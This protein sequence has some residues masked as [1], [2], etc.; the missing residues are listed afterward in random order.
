MKQRLLDFLRR[1]STIAF[2]ALTAL[3]AICMGGIFW[4][5]WALDKAPIEP[6]NAIFYPIDE[7]ARWFR[8]LVAGHDFVPSD[9]MHV[10]GSMYFW[11]ELQYALAG[12]LAALGVV[13]YL[14]GRRVSLLGAYGGGAAYGLMGYTF[15]LFSAGHLGWFVWMMYGPFAFGLVDRCVRKGK[16]RNWALL[17]AVLAW[18][19]ARQSDMWLLFAVLTFLY[20]LW[21]LVREWKR[22]K[23]LRVLAGVCVTVVCLCAVGLPQFMRALTSDLAGREAQI[24]ATSGK[25]TDETVDKSADERWRFCTSWSLPPEDTAEFVCAEIHGGSSDPRVSPKNPYKGRLGQQIVVPQNAAGQRHPVTGET[26]KAGE[27]FWM[28]YRQHSLYFGF[29]TVIFSILGLVGWW[30]YALR[31]PRTA[32]QKPRTFDSAA[33]TA[34]R[35]QQATFS[36][37]PFWIAT[38]VLFY[39]CALG[40]F[41]PFYKLVY[42]LPFGSTLRA[43]VKFV[44]LLEFCVAALAGFGFEAAWRGF[45][46]DGKTANIAVKCIL[47]AAAVGNVANLACIDAKYCAVED[48]AIQKAPNDAADDVVKLDGGKVFTVTDPNLQMQIWSPI[49]QNIQRILTQLNMPIESNHSR[50]IQGFIQDVEP[51]IPVVLSD[52]RLGPSDKNSIIALLKPMLTLSKDP[53]CPLLSLGNREQLTKKIM[54]MKAVQESFGVHL[55]ET[56]TS[57]DDA[58]FFFL[59]KWLYEANAVLRWI[60]GQQ[61]PVGYYSLQKDGIRKAAPESCTFVLLQVEG[62]P[63]P[64]PKEEPVPDRKSQVLTLVSVLATFGLLGWGAWGA[65]RRKRT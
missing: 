53:N 31:K 63:A 48:V 56:A 38:A 60:P 62:V 22:I 7:A 59:P 39:F 51:K 29:L 34:N 55:V 15:T 1:P 43:P 54:K 52:G 40:C 24:A 36:D 57:F 33:P 16:W 32:S 14:R 47:V 50:S 42:A 21:T 45:R 25:S 49:Q 8:E 9:L 3:Y 2:L 44:H 26:L 13:F 23:F 18:A 12:Y 41:T 30:F 4:G 37:V 20:G 64:P 17:G 6:D 61:K 11:Q 35:E 5:T 28:P 19:A 46:R 10:I 65:F 58:R 27:T